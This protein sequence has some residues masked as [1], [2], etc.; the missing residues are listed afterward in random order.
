MMYVL[1]KFSNESFFILLRKVCIRMGGRGSYVSRGKTVGLTVTYSDGSTGHFRTTKDGRTISL[2]GAGLTGSGV[3]EVPRT[4]NE[5]A[6]AARTQGLK[7]TRHN[8]RSLD[9]MD[10]AQNEMRKKVNNELDK[11]W[12][13][14]AGTPRKGWKGH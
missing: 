9:L 8:Q 6:S 12:V 4:L 14:S 11:L 13:R 3:H 2:G 5:I 1:K 7:V 10:G